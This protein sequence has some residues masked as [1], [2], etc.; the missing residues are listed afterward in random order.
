MPM[1]IF[2]A[3]DL[4]AVKLQETALAEAEEVITQ[5]KTAG[6]DIE[7]LDE[8]RLATLTKLRGFRQALIGHRLAIGKEPVQLDGNPPFV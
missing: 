1:H 8:R 5:A 3:S 2:D 4:E 7:D 6:M